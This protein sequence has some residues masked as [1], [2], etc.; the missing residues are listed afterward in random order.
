MN[1]IH[2]P[3]SRTMSKNRLRN[4]TESNR[5]KNRPSAQPTGPTARP[6]RAQACVPREPLTCCN[7][8]APHARGPCALGPCARAPCAPLLRAAA[9]P[10]ARVACCRA[11]QRP[12]RPNAPRAPAPRLRPCQRPPVACAP[13]APARLA[14]PLRAQRP[15]SYSDGQ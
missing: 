8:R 6:G 3:G 13:R 9:P 5:V 15:A 2:E 10:R 12:A 11:P 1:N 4:S 14:A 7:A